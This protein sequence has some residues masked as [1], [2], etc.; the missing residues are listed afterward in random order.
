MGSAMPARRQILVYLDSESLR[1]LDAVVAHETREGRYAGRGAVL[2]ALLREIDPADPTTFPTLA[3][4]RRTGLSF[5]ERCRREGRLLSPDDAGPTREELRAALELLG[6]AEVPATAAEV[7]KARLVALRE[8]P[9]LGR[10]ATARA[11]AL[12]KRAIR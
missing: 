10:S 1:V 2:E 3:T 5:G 7:E 11:A 9:R 6:M 8:R 4:D 12:I